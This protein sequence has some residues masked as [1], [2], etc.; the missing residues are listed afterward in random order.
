M[1]FT[2]KGNS[3]KFF[4]KNESSILELKIDETGNQTGESKVHVITDSI[5]NQEDRILVIQ[6]LKEFRKN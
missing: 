1:S 3:G 2:V 4:I 6:K 5:E